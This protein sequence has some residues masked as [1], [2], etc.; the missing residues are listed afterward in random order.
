MRARESDVDH[1]DAKGCTRDT[2]EAGIASRQMTYTLLRDLG[3]QH[4]GA[5]MPGPCIGLH[6]HAR[7]STCD[8]LGRHPSSRLWRA[9]NLCGRRSRH[10]PGG[11]FSREHS[12]GWLRQHRIQ[13]RSERRATQPCAGGRE[14]GC[15]PGQPSS[16]RAAARNLAKLDDIRNSLKVIG[17]QQVSPSTTSIVKALQKTR[18]GNTNR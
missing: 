3:L 12:A 6:R 14:P 2:A 11:D 15:S 17:Q 1:A 10:H 18:D 13:P 8:W 16:A 7:R 4:I 5:A 9:T